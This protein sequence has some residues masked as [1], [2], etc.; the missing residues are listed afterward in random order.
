MDGADGDDPAASP[1]PFPSARAPLPPPLP[2]LG[3]AGATTIHR[4][5]SE[6][7]SNTHPKRPTKV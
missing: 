4:R 6:K 7:K 3:E 2:P 5:I 1:P